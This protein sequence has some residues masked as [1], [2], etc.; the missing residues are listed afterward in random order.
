MKLKISEVKMDK[1]KLE[2]INGKP[3]IEDQKVM[4]DGLLAYHA[5]KGHPR[6]TENYSVI[7]KDKNSKIRGMIIVSILWNGMHIDSLWVDEQVRN[8]DWG[9]KLMEMVEVEAIR[10]GCTISYTDTFTWQAP[11]F[12][13]KLGY[14]LYGKLENFPKGNSL[15]YYSKNLK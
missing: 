4:I 8:Q 7:L 2:T 9:S 13:E 5:S 6:N 1:F 10:R 15:S 12:Y 14:K 3:N 11:S